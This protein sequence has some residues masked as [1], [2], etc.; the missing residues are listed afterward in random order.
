LEDDADNFN[1]ADA[2]NAFLKE[3]SIF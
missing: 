1:F 2:V 3:C